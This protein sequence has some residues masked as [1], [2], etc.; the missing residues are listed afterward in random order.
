MWVFFST[1]VYFTPANFELQAQVQ[2]LTSVSRFDTLGLPSVRVYT[3]GGFRGRGSG[4][5]PPPSTKM[6]LRPLLRPL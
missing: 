2:S 3:K 4:V 5:R 6:S 1:N